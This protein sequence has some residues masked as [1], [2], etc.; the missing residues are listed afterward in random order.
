MLHREGSCE[1]QHVVLT[2]TSLC[3]G[4]SFLAEPLMQ[5]DA[6]AAEAGLGEGHGV[7]ICLVVATQ[8]CWI[9]VH[10]WH[11]A[12]VVPIVWHAGLCNASCCAA[13]NLPQFIL[14]W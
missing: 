6:F 8:P 10:E 12:W 4:T 2:A 11:A 7:C 14:C 9:D 13:L 1:P 5:H 3:A